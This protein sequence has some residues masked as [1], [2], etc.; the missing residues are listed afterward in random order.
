MGPGP[1]R[2][3]SAARA[4]FFVFWLD[5][6]SFDETSYFATTARGRAAPPWS[7]APR[8]HATELVRFLDVRL[9]WIVNLIIKPTQN[10]MT[11]LC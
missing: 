2:P 1:S 4:R 10:V 9:A 7:P 5:G 11:S 3:A 6:V 8:T